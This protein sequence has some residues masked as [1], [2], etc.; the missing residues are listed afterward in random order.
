[1]LLVERQLYQW[2]STD[3]PEKDPNKYEHLIFEKGGK[4]F[5]GGERTLTVNGVGAT[6]HS[7]AKTNKQ[8]PPPESH[9]LHKFNTN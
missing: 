2:Y 4:Q 5:N 1:M 3:N 9:T 6:G 8:T 7:L